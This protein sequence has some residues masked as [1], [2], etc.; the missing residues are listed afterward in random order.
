[1][2]LK[3]R[4]MEVESKPIVPSKRTAPV[5]NERD[6]K[7]V[8]R[9]RIGPP[10]SDNEDEDME[11][12]KRQDAIPPSRKRKIESLMEVSP[13]ITVPKVSNFA[14]TQKEASISIQK[15]QPMQTTSGNEQSEGLFGADVTG[16]LFEDKKA[17]VS[18]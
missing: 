6:N 12:E 8:R 10:P 11:E 5:A 1:M 4:K 15:T 7:R 17:R 14:P 16:N 18:L 13:I 2:N 3:T 9:N